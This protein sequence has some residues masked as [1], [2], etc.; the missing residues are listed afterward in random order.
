MSQS[1]KKT[2]ITMTRGDTLKL[3]VNLMDASG[4]PYIP[5]EGD[6]MRFACKKDYS[7]TEVLIEKDIPMDTMLLHL[8]PSDTKPLDFGDYV[9][10]MQITFANGDVDTFIDKAIFRLTEE[11]D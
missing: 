4:A 8:E 11:V 1:V 10:D 6:A 7:D 9:Y 2:T 3:T 5:Q